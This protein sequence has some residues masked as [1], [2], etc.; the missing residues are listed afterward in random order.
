M[1]H[2]LQLK[3]ND[4][5][6]LTQRHLKHFENEDDD[7]DNDNDNDRHI[8]T[9]DIDDDN[10]CDTHFYINLL[11]NLSPSME[12][13][14][15]QALKGDLSSYSCNEALTTLLDD[16]KCRILQKQFAQLMF[17]IPAE[18]RRRLLPKVPIPPLD[19]S[20]A[21]FRTQLL[22]LS[23]IPLK[24]ENSAVLDE[25]ISVIPL[26]DIYSNAEYQYSL[27]R[28]QAASL[29]LSR[30]KWGHQDCVVRDLLRYAVAYFHDLLVLFIVVGMNLTHFLGGSAMN[31]S[32][33]SITLP[34]PNVRGPLSSKA[35]PNL[36]QR[37]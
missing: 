21:R 9:D 32:P 5:E 15:S 25:A 36:I 2:N 26:E 30:P 34:V 37:R 17:E 35:S 22:A 14:H 28:A 23:K 10:E 4:I 13:V 3:L 29:G 20:A 16:A 18:Q 19:A 27:Q 6:D 11:M 7:N 24:Y 33:L 12:Q 31:S 1:T 8:H